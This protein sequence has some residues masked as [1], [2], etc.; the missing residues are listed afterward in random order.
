MALWWLICVSGGSLW[1]VS[2]SSAAELV[3]VVVSAP[4]AD[5]SMRAGLDGLLPNSTLAWRLPHNHQKNATPGWARRRTGP[6]HHRPGGHKPGQDSEAAL[7]PY[8]RYLWWLV[9]VYLFWAQA[10]VCDDYFVP[11]IEA[12][13]DKLQIPDDIAG[14]TIMALGCNGPELFINTVAMFKKSDLGIGAVMGGE[15]FNLLVLTG[16]ALLATPAMYMPLRISKFS[17]CRDVGFYALSIGLIYWV[18]YDNVVTLP[19]AIVL[20]IGGTAYSTFVGFSSSLRRCL[21]PVRP[22]LHDSASS[23]TSRENSGQAAANHQSL[24]T[25]SNHV[26]V[27][28]CEEEEQKDCGL[29]PEEGCFLG[30]RVQ[31]GNRMQDR[32]RHWDTRFVTLGGSSLIISTDV[33]DGNTMRFGRTA[34]GIVF[35]HGSN[36]GVGS[37][38][39]GGLVNAP[40]FNNEG[41]ARAMADALN[42]GSAIMEDPLQ[43]QLS[44][45][46]V[47]IPRATSDPEAV[48]ASLPTELIPLTDIVCCVAPL[49]PTLSHFELQVLQRETTLGK[50]VTLELDAKSVLMR[51]RWIMAIKLGMHQLTRAREQEGFAA[52]SSA[53]GSLVESAVTVGPGASHTT[54]LWMEVVDWFRFPVKFLLR[55]TIPNV[56]EDRWKKCMPLCF[57]MSMAWLALFSFCV[58]EVCDIIA[59]EFDI[60]VTILGF[61]VA[62]IGTSFPNVISCIAV[63]RQGKTGMAIANALGA[64]IQN[65]FVALALPWF[66]KALAVGSF[67]VS[68]GDLT[69]SILAMVVTLVM[70][71]MVVLIAGCKM[72]KWAGVIFLVMY[73]AYLILQFGEEFGCAS[74][75]VCT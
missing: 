14:A 41:H 17:F 31:M 4:P 1:P 3:D 45:P 6:N 58:V 22:I 72:P 47:M 70:L 35:Q 30:V 19:K 39:H 59:Y 52:L 66:V 40:T 13:S 60:S 46:D 75:P 18:L 57:M 73:V 28:P 11:T 49:N 23:P 36:G 33:R 50:V 54:P 65:V 74:W 63:S 69:A 55:V 7:T 38:C 32:S 9:V 12:I 29:G 34:R 20:L 71:V 56:R 67:A 25:G 10:L 5:W 61:T 16:C 21:T 43:R 51:D 64:N 48:V 68:D 26:L 2:A 8:L 53:G 37:W 44:P 15:V 27:I 24:G 42:T 62:A